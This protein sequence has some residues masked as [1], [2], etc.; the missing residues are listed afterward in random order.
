MPDTSRDA[1]TARQGTVVA[2]RSLGAARPRALLSPA[3]ARFL[4]VAALALGA[5]LL[6][7]LFSSEASA[8]EAPAGE[9]PDQGV[10]SLDLLSGASANDTG[11]DNDDNADN[12][13]S[14]E[15]PAEPQRQGLLPD[16]RQV[17]EP[18]TETVTRPVRHLTGSLLRPEGDAGLLGTVT[19]TVGGAVDGVRNTVD[20][21][22]GTVRDTLAPVVELPE[23]LPGLGDTLPADLT[24]A[25]GDGGATAP[26]AEPRETPPAAGRAAPRPPAPAGPAAFA[27]TSS[28]TTSWSPEPAQDTDDVRAGGGASPGR[29]PLGSLPGSVSVTCGVAT[30]HNSPA[31]R[32]LLGIMNRSADL[33][34]PAPAG[35][36]HA[37]GADSE[38]LQ[39][40]LPD[41][42]PD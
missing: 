28:H 31:G 33:A 34:S 8:D 29:G 4:V 15:A 19:G 18:V 20:G 9:R 27:P 1:T 26:S 5:W 3:L 10:V 13:D 37:A 36:S 42:A 40:S 6:A 11:E 39:A 2:V 38:I 22:T 14:A 30:Q 24:P 16:L 35:T 32:G 41:T 17:T 23:S 7:A 21:L 25:P 12:E